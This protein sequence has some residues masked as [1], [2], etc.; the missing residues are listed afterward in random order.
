MRLRAMR[1]VKRVLL[2]GGCD[3]VSYCVGHALLMAR[4]ASLRRALGRVRPRRLRIEHKPWPPAVMFPR[5]GEPRRGGA[6][7]EF[8][9][10]NDARFGD[11]G[12]WTG[13]VCAAGPSAGSTSASTVAGTTRDRS[14]PGDCS[15]FG[16]TGPSRAALATRRPLHDDF[17]TSLPRGRVRVSRDSPAVIVRASSCGRSV[18]PRAALRRPRSSDR[19]PI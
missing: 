13:I 10:R 18:R 5:V 12:R 4:R 11:E 8:A 17:T 6:V 15:R 7:R 1:A 2:L 19:L 9:L 16:F 14:G 3:T